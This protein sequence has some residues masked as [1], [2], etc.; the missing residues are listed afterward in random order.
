MSPH[1]TGILLTILVYS[2]TK[3]SD[4]TRSSLNGRLTA[5]HSRGTIDSQYLNFVHGNNLS[6]TD[7]HIPGIDSDWGMLN[8]LSP[9]RR[10]AK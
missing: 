1:S 8:Y 4:F 10:A 6:N 3:L 9:M 7:W 2:S 5:L